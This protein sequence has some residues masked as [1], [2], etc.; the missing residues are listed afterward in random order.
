MEL[1]KIV[2]YSFLLFILAAASLF[3]WLYKHQMKKAEKT[4]YIETGPV[5]DRLY[6]VDAII[7]L[8]VLLVGLLVFII[9][10]NY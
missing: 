5:L 3:N 4:M 8:V 10:L 9:S 1:I 6:S 2:L 7:P